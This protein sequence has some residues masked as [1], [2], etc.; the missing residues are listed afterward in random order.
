MNS[1]LLMED[2]ICYRFLNSFRLVDPM[3][4]LY[5]IRNLT[6][7]L[8]NMQLNVPSSLGLHVPRGLPFPLSLPLK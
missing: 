4:R 5:P 6:A 2:E 3:S 7:R 8:R 1:T